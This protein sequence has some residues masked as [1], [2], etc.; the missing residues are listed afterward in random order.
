MCDTL[1]YCIVFYYLLPQRS[2][3]TILTVKTR[4]YDRG[5]NQYF[6]SHPEVFSEISVPYDNTKMYKCRIILYLRSHF[7]ACF[8][9]VSNLDLELFFFSTAPTLL[10]KKYC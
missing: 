5:E 3:I 10:E 7:F 1:I 6:S 9:D 2:G 8:I 4:M